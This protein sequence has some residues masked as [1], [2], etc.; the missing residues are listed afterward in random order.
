MVKKALCVGLNYPT[1]KFKLYGCINDCLDWDYRLKT[2]FEFDESRV[3]IDQNPDGS[4]AT[5]PTQIPTRANILAQL[6]WLCMDVQPGDCLVFVFA[7]HGCQVSTG[8]GRVDEA[9]VPEDFSESPDAPLVFDDE[10]HALFQQLPPG[11]CLTLI[12]DCC[13]GA[14]MLDVP[15]SIDTSHVPS[16]TLSTCERPREVLN[17]T[18]AAWEKACLSRAQARPR[19]IPRVSLTA[20]RQRRTQ[21][22]AGAHVGRMTLDPGVTA[23]CFAAARTPE[24]ALDAN[25]KK[26]QCGVMSFCLLEALEALKNRCTYEM[27]LEKATERLEDIREKYM[28][29]MDQHLHLSFCPYSTPSQVVVFDD[30]YAGVAQYKLSQQAPS[31]DGS[32][33]EDGGAMP[34]PVREVSTDFVPAPLYHPPEAQP[35]HAPQGRSHSQSDSPPARLYLIVHAAYSL[36]SITG[37]G[38]CDPFVVTRVGHTEHRTPTFGSNVEPLWEKENHFTFPVHERD[39]SLDL[40]VRNAAT[41]DLLG[42]TGVDLKALP[43]REWHRRRLRLQDQYGRSAGDADLEFDVRLEPLQQQQRE[44]PPQQREQAPQ[45]HRHQRPAPAAD[46]PPPQPQR[47]AAQQPPHTTVPNSHDRPSSGRGPPPSDRPPSPM[48]Q[49]FARPPEQLPHRTTSGF[50]GPGTSAGSYVPPPLGGGGGSYVPPPAGGGGGAGSYVAPPLAGPAAGGC[51]GP[52]GG[53]PG[54]ASPMPPEQLGWPYPDIFGTPNLLGAMPNLLSDMLAN[55]GAAVPPVGPPA[56]PIGMPGRTAMPSVPY[57]AMSQACAY[58]GVYT[59]A[60]Y[61]VQASAYDGMYLGQ[62]QLSQVSYL[63]SAMA[64]S[65]SAPCSYSYAPSAYATAGPSSYPAAAASSAP[66]A[67]ASGASS[68]ATSATSLYSATPSTYTTAAPA[69]YTTSGASY[70]GSVADNVYTSA[71]VTYEMPAVTYTTSSGGVV[72]SKYGA[73]A[74]VVQP[75]SYVAQS[76]SRTYSAEPMVQT[77]SAEPLMNGVYSA[78]SALPAASVSA[79]VVTTTYTQQPA[80]GSAAVSQ[81][82]GYSPYPQGRRLY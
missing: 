23:F 2:T 41:Q 47:P 63:P 66:Y 81:A 72:T 42:R 17:R 28:P 40:E 79:P 39:L 58:D 37:S 55:A 74:S 68:Y 49:D 8:P 80:S 20:P 14:H 77:Y 78:G 43:P 45:E 3:L 50:G 38:P 69:A 56:M 5:V 75:G 26:H 9:L 71:P 22:G 44:Q 57:P 60:P 46:G 52:G 11:S 54:G 12:L 13:H 73:P 65:A 18:E 29:T 25:I 67:V 6:G 32:L 16:R 36:A 7:G 27:L 35:H 59:G 30:R 4:L 33:L 51:S 76:S 1:H 82:I 15:T 21:E 70:P 24:A 10:L 64:Y 61:E 31:R 19:F 62:Q 34:T 48:R 53:R